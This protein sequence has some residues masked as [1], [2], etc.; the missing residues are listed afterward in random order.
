MKLLGGCIIK[1][2]KCIKSY[3]NYEFFVLV[4]EFETLKQIDH[5]EAQNVL[6]DEQRPMLFEGR[7]Q[8]FVRIHQWPE[9][10]ERLGLAPDL[11][12]TWTPEQ[13]ERFLTGWQNDEVL[14]QINHGEKR[15][16]DEMMGEEPSTSHQGAL[17]T[18]RGKVDEYERPFYVE[19]VRQVCTKKFKA[20]ATRYRV[21]FINVLADVE[22][23]SL[24][25]LHEIFQQIL[26][27]T[28][29]GVPPQDQVCFLLHSN[30]LDKPNHFPF[31]T[32]DR[33]TMKHILAKF[34]QVIQSNQEFRLNDTVEIN[35]IHVSM[36]IGGKGSKRSEVTLEK[37]LEKKRSIVRIQN[38][39]DLCMVQALVV[40][41]AKL[42]NDTRDRHIR[43][44]N[45]PL[46]TRLAQE[47]HQ[48]AGIPLG[49]CGIEQAKL[50][51]AYLTEYQINI[52]SKEYNN[53]IIYAGPEKDKR[54][55]LYINDNHYDVITKMPGF[56]APPVKVL[57]DA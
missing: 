52:V 32:A 27:E 33:L 10:N 31:M 9:E 35:V 16:Y 41:K 40:A 51:Q 54:I 2:L 23:T 14:T 29:G 1:G 8:I 45:R 6:T 39:D 22:I 55:Y 53:N 11:T 26:D 5:Y 44:S 56:F 12:D 25:E 46:Q 43:M 20:N 49:P 42:D 38:D 37:H 50:F 48:N 3:V 30:Q 21:Q 19:S 34:E 15:T 13:R 17:Q 57:S 18:G 47:L 24:H 36:P 7:M 28:I 4:M